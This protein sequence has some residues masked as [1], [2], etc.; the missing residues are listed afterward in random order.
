MSPV[1]MWLIDAPS[2]EMIVIPPLTSVPTQMLP[3]PSTH[4]ESSNWYPGS[5]ARHTL[6]SSGAAGANSPGAAIVRLNTRPVKV[7][8]QYSVEP[9]GDS[10][11]PL[12]ASTGCT[13]SLM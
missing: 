10:P 12:G 3:S 9:S 13:C 5:P 8:A 11:I 1:G 4:S 7:S 6:G 2:G